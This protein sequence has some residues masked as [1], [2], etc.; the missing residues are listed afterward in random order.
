MLNKKK[1]IISYDEPTPKQVF[2]FLRDQ[3]ISMELVPGQKISENSLAERFGVSRTPIREAIVTLVNLGFVEVRPQRGTFVSKLSMKKIVEARF[4]REALEVAIASYV[5]KN[6][7]PQLI[8]QCEEILR[9][10]QETIVADD[11]LAF[12]NLD[13]AFHQKLADFT[14]FER[15]G[16]LIKSEKA[17]M[18][19]VRNLSL[20][21]FGGQYDKMLAQHSDILEAIK[22]SDSERACELTRIHMQEVLNTLETVEITHPDFFA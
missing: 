10:Q 17:H 5:A 14:Q 4:I 3:I 7:T 15:A 2:D 19:R 22:Q 16:I 6:H 13:D 11:A 12:Q 18:D 20:Q 9:L 1:L 8:R 21:E